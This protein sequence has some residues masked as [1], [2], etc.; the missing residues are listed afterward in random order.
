MMGPSI[1]VI[2]FLWVL[3]WGTWRLLCG[4]PIETVIHVWHTAARC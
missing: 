2:F 4:W 3:H 1:A